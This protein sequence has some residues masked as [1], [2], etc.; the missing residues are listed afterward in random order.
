MRV[1]EKCLCNITFCPPHIVALVIEGCKARFISSA[2]Q[3]SFRDMANP[4]EEA[5]DVTEG[6]EVGETEATPL[7]G[8]G[9]GAGAGAAA[10]GGGV[11][12]GGADASGGGHG[13]GGGDEAEIGDEEE[14]DAEEEDI[15]E[16][17]GLAVAPPVADP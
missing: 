1:D 9:G 5:V 11:G 7:G 2:L 4:R 6:A 12:V 8:G 17:D 15:E 10:G 3:A 16:D 13:V 14:E